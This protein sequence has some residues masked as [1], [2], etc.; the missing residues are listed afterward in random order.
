MDQYQK[1]GFTTTDVPGQHQYPI[2][3]A[4]HQIAPNKIDYQYQG[5]TKHTITSRFSGFSHFHA[6]QISARRHPI[7]PKMPM[8]IPLALPFQVPPSM[9]I[10]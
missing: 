6:F 2:T 7:L 9:A 4:L 8:D 5:H 3:L 1:T 10:N